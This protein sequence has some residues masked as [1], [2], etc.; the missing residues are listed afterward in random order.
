MRLWKPRQERQK[1]QGGASGRVAAPAATAEEAEVTITRLLA[2]WELRVRR[3]RLE[4][5]GALL[6]RPDRPGSPEML[7]ARERVIQQLAALGPTAL[8]PLL[9][10]LR[11]AVANGL[12]LGRAAIAAR[13][14]GRMGDFRA[15]PALLA[16]LRDQRERAAPVRVAAA[17]ALGELKAEAAATLY[18]RALAQQSD[19]DWQAQLKL[20]G[21]LRLET[22]VEALVEALRDPAPEVRA[23]AADACIDLCLAEPPPPL[24][25]ADVGPAPSAPATAS[26]REAVYSVLR[27]AVEPLGEALK[28]ADA[29]VRANAA[30]ALGWIGDP[31]AAAP[32]MKCLKDADE[33][34]R[35]AAAQALGML[36]SPVALRALARALGDTSAAVR[37]Q[38]AE[39]LGEVGDPITAD[40]LLDALADEEEP[41]EVRAAAARA[42]GSLHL[43]QALPVLQELLRASEPALRLAAV[44]ALCRLGFGRV[45]RLLVPLLWRDRDRAVRHAA[46][47][48]VARLASARQ[49]R[50]RWRL[51]LALR[52]ARPARREALAILDEHA[53]RTRQALR[54]R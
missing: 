8:E 19:D 35:A 45:Y 48:A 4:G 2:E 54:E 16:A 24:G 40:L 23:A 26:S 44:E 27:L 25:F 51:R 32:L 3:L 7:A 21:T 10:V 12:T 31:R 20:L 15:A 28:D 42:L 1:P 43:P 46:A 36:R 18:G 49:R 22:V 34:C 5:S 29:A 17:A 13:A 39:S 30:A 9:R 50:A 33:R 52:V 6:N 47:R 53:R 11:P 38:V 37:Q 41:L 14:L